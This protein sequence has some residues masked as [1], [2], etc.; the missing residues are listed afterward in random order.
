M[1]VLTLTTVISDAILWTTFATNRV[2]VNCNNIN[3]IIS[4]L[5]VGIADDDNDDIK[6]TV[7]MKNVKNFTTEGST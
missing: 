5:C 7:K 4:K 2:I 1:T 6:C 3:S